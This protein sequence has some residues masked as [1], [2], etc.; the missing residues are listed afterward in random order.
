MAFCSGLTTLFVSIVVVTINLKCIF[1]Q[2]GV[3]GQNVVHMESKERNKLFSSARHFHYHN[4][5][6]LFS[7]LEINGHL[8]TA[9]HWV[10][11]EEGKDVKVREPD[12]GQAEVFGLSEYGG[13]I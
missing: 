2:G 6:V 10:L 5:I 1:G 9:E 4:L 7:L 13:G 11:G 8:W 12:M 3:P